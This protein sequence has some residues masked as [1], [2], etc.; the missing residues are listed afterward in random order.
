MPSKN[1]SRL[2][3]SK[4]VP[5]LS[6][7]STCLWHQALAVSPATSWLTFQKASSS[8]MLSSLLTWHKATAQTWAWTK[9]RFVK[10]VTQWKWW[11]GPYRRPQLGG[12][13]NT[14]HILREDSKDG[15][16]HRAPLLCV[17]SCFENLY[18]VYQRKWVLSKPPIQIPLLEQLWVRFK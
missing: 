7:H 1:P 14:D 13:G 6:F 5:S 11:G 16:N 4:W 3:A 12:E 17:L 8:H 18:F 2:C 15:E 9:P 10:L